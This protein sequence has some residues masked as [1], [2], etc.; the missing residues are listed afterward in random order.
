MRSGSCAG[1]IAAMVLAASA[2]ADDE[3]NN[4]VAYDETFSSGGGV[5]A[6]ALERLRDAGLERVI[7]LAYSDQE[8]SLENEDRVVDKLGMDFVH[9]P[10]RWDAPDANHFG[11]F[12]AI[13][14]QAPE[15]PTL[16]HCQANYR[17]SAFAMLY[18][19]IYDNV[20]L[21]EAKA[22][23]NAVW[24]PTETWTDFILDTLERNGVDA[25]CEGCDWTPYVPED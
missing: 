8:Q 21:A 5:T 17:A 1:L 4:Y 11:L 25:N 10:V 22:D 14:Q 16:V 3:V 2:Q 18:R 19:V 20:P 9:I 7:F 23:M 12:A 13:M 6:P 15:R 24:T